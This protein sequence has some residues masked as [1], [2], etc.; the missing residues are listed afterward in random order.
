VGSAESRPSQK[1]KHEQLTSS[2]GAS[3]EVLEKG[4]IWFFYR[5]KTEG[6]EDATG[7]KDVQRLYLLLAPNTRD[8]KQ[9]QDSS[10][11]KRLLGVGRKALP[12]PAE[13]GRPGVRR[14][15]CFVD[16][17]TYNVEG[18]RAYRWLLI[19]TKICRSSLASTSALRRLAALG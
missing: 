16:A 11:K 3:T 4:L 13:G 5:P 7:P 14:T 6:E 1:R 18:K 15:W 10:Q 12:A 19:F 2:Q 17:V 9:L 8:T